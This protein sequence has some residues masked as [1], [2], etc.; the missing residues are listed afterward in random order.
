MEISPSGRPRLGL[1]P[2]LRTLESLRPATLLKIAAA[3]CVIP[4]P[5]HKLLVRT[6]IVASGLGTHSVVHARGR[7]SLRSLAS[8]GYPLTW[9][10]SY[11]CHTRRTQSCTD[12]KKVFGYARIR[13][14]H[15]SVSIHMELG[16]HL[17]VLGQF[18]CID[19]SRTRG[20][21]SKHSMVIRIEKGILKDS[22][23]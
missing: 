12:Q 17:R 23:I 21:L 8:N 4:K 22:R 5:F 15:A 6:R 11:H 9:N 1:L 10:S 16:S 20:I 3:G 19:A 18:E 7:Y 2:T 14:I 13:L